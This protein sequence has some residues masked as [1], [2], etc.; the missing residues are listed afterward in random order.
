MILF[1]VLHNVRKLCIQVGLS[2]AG[3]GYHLPF[4]FCY[5]PVLFNDSFSLLMDLLLLL[6]EEIN[7]RRNVRA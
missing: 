4:F 3:R 7:D 1:K 2:V 6:W 5:S